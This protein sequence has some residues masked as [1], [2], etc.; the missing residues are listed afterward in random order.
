MRHA[1]VEYSGFARPK[2]QKGG[3]SGSSLVDRKPT[4]KA[5]CNGCATR[6]IHVAGR[7]PGQESLL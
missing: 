4:G 3:G 6:R 5:I 2:S 7:F 1:W